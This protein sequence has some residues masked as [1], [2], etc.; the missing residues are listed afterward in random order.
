[1]RIAAFSDVHGNAL[2]LRAVLADARA[3][4]CDLL[5]HLGD[6]F[7]GPLWPGETAALLRDLDAIHV[8]GN[9]D[10]AL[11]APDEEPPGPGEAFALRELDADTLDWMRG[12]VRTHAIGRDLLLFHGSP[13][14]AGHY[15]LDEAPHGDPRL[16]STQDIAGDLDGHD[17]R[18]LVG[19]HSHL[20][21]VVALPDGRIVV[22]DGSV[23]LQAFVDREGGATRR[24][25]TGSPHARYAMIELGPVS[26]GVSIL[27]VDYDW[28]AARDK[29]AAEGWA[30]WARWLAGRA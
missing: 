20:P 3:R 27:A 16:R 2:A 9:H 23:G 24:H 19:G 5:C 6:A 13:S 22:N 14:K 8:L 4:G 11:I 15:L 12:W 18:V 26:V 25:Q 17:A 29:A 21:R 30:S 28:R 1:M 7:S 10:L